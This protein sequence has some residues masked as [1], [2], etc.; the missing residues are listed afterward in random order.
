MSDTLQYNKL[1]DTANPEVNLTTRDVILRGAA[2]TLMQNDTAK[3]IAGCQTAKFVQAARA[4]YLADG[5][6]FS[7]EDLRTIHE[8]LRELVVRKMLG[9]NYKAL[10]LQ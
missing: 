2:E 6:D 1:L 9:G 10:R 7:D 5:F 4:S 8:C 3:A